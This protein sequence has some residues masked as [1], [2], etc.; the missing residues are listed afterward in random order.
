MVTVTCSAGSFCSWQVS[1]CPSTRSGPPFLDSTH[2]VCI[3]L[4][5]VVYIKLP[6]ISPFFPSPPLLSSPPSPLPSGTSWISSHS[7]PCTKLFML[8]AAAIASTFRAKMVSD[9]PHSAATLT[10]YRLQLL[11]HSQHYSRDQP[12][13]PLMTN[14]CCLLFFLLSL[15]SPLHSQLEVSVSYCLYSQS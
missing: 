1:C 8:A 13:L 6:C 5:V 2:P 12:Y 14:S 7:L 10:S 4:Y 9:T 11:P 3:S 15:L